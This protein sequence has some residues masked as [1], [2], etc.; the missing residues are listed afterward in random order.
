MRHAILLPFASG[1]AWR[2]SPG[3][4]A[5]EAELCC[6]S[7]M[8]DRIR[9][10]SAATLLRDCMSE[11]PGSPWCQSTYSRGAL[12]RLRPLIL[13]PRRQS[14]PQSLEAHAHNAKH[15]DRVAARRGEGLTTGSGRTVEEIGVHLFARSLVV[16]PEAVLHIDLHCDRRHQESSVGGRK[17]GSARGRERERGVGVTHCPLD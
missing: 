17:H 12:G 15:R 16:G 9:H 8:F 14:H 7:N 10:D 3:E 1:Q 2:A 5:Q 11:Q 6:N 4:D 13:S